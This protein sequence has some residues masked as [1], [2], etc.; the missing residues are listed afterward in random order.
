MLNETSTDA[1]LTPQ[2][3][4][5]LLNE[6][7]T[8]TRAAVKRYLPSGTPQ[9]YLYDLLADYPERGGKMMRSTLCI[10]TACAFGARFEDALGS[11]V[12][13][14]LLHNALLI[15]D[16]IED[17]SQERRGRPTLHLLHGIPLA[18]NAGDTLSLL[19]LR[20]LTD[21][22]ARIGPR[23]T[24][25]ILEEVQRMAWE[26]AEGQ[27]MEL[28]WRRD[29]CHDLSD[30]D[31]LTMVLKKTCWLASIYPCRIG[32]LIGTR[33]RMSLDPFIRFGF[34]LGAAFQIQDDLLNLEGDQRY[35]K[36]L[37]GDI[38]E[39]KRTLMLN[40]VYRSATADEQ[41]R[42]GDILAL[43]REQRSARQIDW[44]RR[45]MDRYGSIGY[46]RQIAHG[47]AGAAL[48]EYTAIFD[49]LPDSR[50]KAFIRGLATWVFERT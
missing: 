2:L 21:N 47:L 34:F 30:A 22:V 48:H 3:I 15:H 11:A 41:Q 13:I 5:E 44:I 26:S 24:M 27:A 37:Q 45:L 50:D 23:L 1:I 49:P 10:A 16:D 25:N 18:I 14:E 12:A 19:S 35:G 29:N 31:Y 43:A 9:N 8:L 38:W 17:E 28:G 7:G 4:P 42:I 33:G 6:Y 39:G 36:E 46:A 40:H 32:A 20:P